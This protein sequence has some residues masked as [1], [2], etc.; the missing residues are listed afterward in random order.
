VV[1]PASSRRSLGE[2][3]I[4][5]WVVQGLAWGMI[6]LPFALPSTAWVLGWVRPPE[7][8]RKVVEAV[9]V[10]PVVPV[11]VPEDGAT[12]GVEAVEPARTGPEADCPGAPFPTGGVDGPGPDALAKTTAPMK[13]VKLRAGAFTMGSELGSDDERPCHRVELGGFDIAVHEVT[14]AQ[15]RLVMKET[16]PSDCIGKCLDSAPVTDVSWDDAVGFL[17]RLSA[18]ENLRA[19]YRDG[20]TWDPTCDGYRLPTEAE[21]EYAARA[22]TVGAYSFEGGTDALAKYAWAGEGFSSGRAHPVG[23]KEANPW[24]LHDMHGNVW[25][26][27]QDGYAPYGAEAVPD[28]GGPNTGESRVWRGGSFAYEPGSLRSALRVRAW[29]SDSLRFNGFRVAR[30]ARPQPLA[31]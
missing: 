20:G 11:P 6:S 1:T 21:W 14:N 26:W 28:A 3:S 19:C 24:G 29:P 18:N 31:R 27:V 15:W 9:L 2:L 4:P 30:G 13:F 5:A 17:N 12:G 16:P 22:G 10:V 7:P 23:L 25:E 8:E